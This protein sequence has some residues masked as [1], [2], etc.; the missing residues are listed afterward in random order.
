MS[1]IEKNED[2][3]GRR[4]LPSSLLASWPRLRSNSGLDSQ[5]EQVKMGETLGIAHNVFE[6][7]AREKDRKERLKKFDEWQKVK[8]RKQQRYQS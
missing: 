4:P 3:G 1:A 6:K 8:A 7:V 5:V 2:S